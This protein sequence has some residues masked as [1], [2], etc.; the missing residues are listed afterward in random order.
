MTGFDVIALILACATSAALRT[1]RSRAEVEGEAHRSFIPQEAFM[2]SLPRSL[3]A[4]LLCTTALIAAAPGQAEDAVLVSSTVERYVPGS[5]ITDDQ[6][7]ALAAGARATLL[8]RSGGIIQVKGPFEGRLDALRPPGALGGAEGLV[9]ALRGQGV[10]AS[11]AGATRGFTMPSARAAMT[12]APVNVDVRNSAIYCIG[13]NDTLWLRASSDASGT[14]R[15]RR[16]RSIREVAWPEGAGRIAWPADVPVEDGDRF[17]VVDGTD[18]VAATM[19]FHR[20]DPPSSSTAWIAAGLL[21]GCRTQVEPALREL[22][23]EIEKNAGK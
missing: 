4:A 21:S 13:P 10:E 20:F 6:T 17:E 19:I 14:I 22:A 9:Q 7:L 2:T 18:A 3:L 5:V 16:G 11:V 1:M 8:F 12:G 15:L 23:L